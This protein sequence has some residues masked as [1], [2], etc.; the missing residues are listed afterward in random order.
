MENKLVQLVSHY[1]SL[2]DG[3]LKTIGTQPKMCP[4]GFWTEGYGELIL[5]AQKKPLKGLATRTTA[6][7]FAKIHTKEEA[8]EALNKTL[9]EYRANVVKLV[10]NIDEDKISAL[11]SFSYNVGINALRKST[12][13]KNILAGADNTTIEKNF[14]AWTKAGGKTLPGLIYRRKSEALLFTTGELKFFN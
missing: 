13:L 3:D 2:H 12:L 10:G 9:A 5:D 6:Y 8:L 1:E 4:A 11:I 7:K 14:M